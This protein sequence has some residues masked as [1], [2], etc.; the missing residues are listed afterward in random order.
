MLSVTFWGY[1]NTGHPL[2]NL[3]LRGKE[4]EREKKLLRY[5]FVFNNVEEL[6]VVFFITN[7]ECFHVTVVFADAAGWMSSQIH[8][9]TK[10][11]NSPFLSTCHR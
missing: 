8:G 5:C 7:I 2:L 6:I 3:F 4:R 11:E 1:A 10:I 9:W